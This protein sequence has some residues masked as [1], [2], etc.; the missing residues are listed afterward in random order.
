MV[1]NRRP[2]F[3]SSLERIIWSWFLK[4]I[5][6]SVKPRFGDFLYSV[7]VPSS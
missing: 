4:K 7:K 3:D 1:V 2:R 5:A 6:S